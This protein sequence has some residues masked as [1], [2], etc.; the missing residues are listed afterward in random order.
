[1]IVDLVEHK[2][3]QL[4]SDILDSNKKEWKIRYV[5]FARTGFT[6][7]AKTEMKKYGGTLVDLKG[8]EKAL[9]SGFEKSDK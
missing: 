5:V 3:P 6:Q 7:A 4:L 2:T 1:M 9:E 8:I